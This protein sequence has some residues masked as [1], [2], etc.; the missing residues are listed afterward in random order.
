LKE[1][2]PTKTSFGSSPEASAFGVGVLLGASGF[3]SSLISSS[4]ESCFLATLACFFGGSLSLSSSED[5]SF[6]ALAG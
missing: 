4:S 1:R 3:Y 2:F 6:F 5:E